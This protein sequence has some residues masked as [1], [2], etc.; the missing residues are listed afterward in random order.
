MLKRYLY[1]FTII[2]IGCSPSNNR[3]IYCDKVS[4]YLPVE[5]MKKKNYGNLNYIKNGI[6]SRIYSKKRKDSLIQTIL[7]ETFENLNFEIAEGSYTK[8]VLVDLKRNGSNAKKIKTFSV[9]GKYKF[10]VISHSE[11]E[12]KTDLVYF[13]SKHENKYYFIKVKGIYSI[14]LKE[15]TE[16]V[17][18]D[19][20]NSIKIDTTKVT[21]KAL[22]MD[23][24]HVQQYL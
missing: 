24:T 14:E 6:E 7:I 12:S 11:K 16:K 20:I 2:I 8:D 23:T 21:N 13:N 3:T 4:F 9:G 15:E 5:W 1:L 10:E 22:Y 18:I 19:L 17:I